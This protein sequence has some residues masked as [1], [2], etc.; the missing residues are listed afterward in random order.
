MKWWE[1]PGLAFDTETTGVDAHTDRIVTAAIAHVTPGK[2]PVITQWL[3]GPEMDVPTEA[4]LVHGW[5]TERIAARLNGAP[6]ARLIDGHIDYLTRQ[7]ALTQIS[8]YLAC[9]ITDEVPV[10][11][12]NAAFDLTLIEA[13]LDRN[14][15]P[16]LSSRPGGITGVVDPMVIDKA[17]DPFRKSCYRAPGCNVD[18]KHHECGGCR[19]GKHRCGRCGATD[20]TLTSLCL[21]YG[22]RLGNAHDAGADAVA[23]ARLAYRLMD[24]WPDTARLR[25]ATLHDHQVAWRREQMDSL[26]SY[27][28]KNGIEHDGCDPSWPLL[29]RVEQPALAFGGLS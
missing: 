17:F 13:E 19:G 23:A 1:G 10:I 11:A 20:R 8:G 27:F 6:A 24:A 9:A 26:R 29:T 25:L 18:T 2:P 21:H 22:V 5:T 15:L 3:I 7:D 16:T 14:N 4:A 28:D 12:A